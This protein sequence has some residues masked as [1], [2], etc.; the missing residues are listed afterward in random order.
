M[1]T[2]T[3]F[4][5]RI[6][7]LAG[8]LALLVLGAGP[9][10]AA[11]LELAQALEEPLPV[12]AADAEGLAYGSCVA[13]ALA[14]GLWAVAAFCAAGGIL[15]ARWCKANYWGAARWLCYALV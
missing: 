2:L 1:K 11:S 3:N 7:M 5:I 12:G 14:A 10:S 4:R 9:A 6:G 8:L 15:N 13:A